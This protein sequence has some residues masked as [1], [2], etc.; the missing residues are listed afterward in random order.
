MS[1][2]FITISVAKAIVY[3]CEFSK[4]E[5]LESKVVSALVIPHAMY[6]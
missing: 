4:N 5:T 3:Q 6:A 2:A 1:V